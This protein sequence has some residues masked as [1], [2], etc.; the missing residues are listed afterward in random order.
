MD[1]GTYQFP[2]R[3]QRHVQYRY[4]DEVLYA[5]GTYLLSI[6]PPKNPSPPPPDL[7]ARGREVFRRERCEVCHPAPNYTTGGL[8]P[9]AGYTPPPDH[10]NL[11]DVFNRSAGTATRLSV[12]PITRKA[13]VTLCS[14]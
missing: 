1:F 11:S 14:E 7:V 9:A 10:P 12:H 4:A 6:E 2:A 5:I 8:T 3:E 13:G